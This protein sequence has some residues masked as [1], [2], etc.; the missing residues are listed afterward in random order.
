[1]DEDEKNNEEMKVKALKWIKQTEKTCRTHSKMRMAMGSERG[2]SLS[3]IE[4]HIEENCN[5]IV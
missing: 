3:K 5:I 1:M 2:D 4:A